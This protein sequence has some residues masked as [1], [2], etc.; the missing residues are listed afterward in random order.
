M[1]NR[2]SSSSS[3]DSDSE[4][5]PS[6][7]SENTQAVERGN[8]GLLV[9]S[10]VEVTNGTISKD[11]FQF[12]EA[13]VV[14]KDIKAFCKLSDFGKVYGWDVV[15][16]IGNS[17]LALGRNDFTYLCARMGRDK[18][19]DGGARGS[20]TPESSGPSNLRVGS[21]AEP[22]L[23]E[24]CHGSKE[25]NQEKSGRGRSYPSWVQQ[26]M[27]DTVLESVEAPFR[28]FGR[29]F[30]LCDVAKK[31]K[32]WKGFP[33]FVAAK[34]EEGGHP[35]FVRKPHH[36]RDVYRKGGFKRLC[37]RLGQDPE[38]KDSDV[39]PEGVKVVN[40]RLYLAGFLSS[41]NPQTR[42]RVK[43]VP[44]V[45][46]IILATDN[47]SCLSGKEQSGE[48]GFTNPAKVQGDGP[49]GSEA[50]TPLY[51]SRQLKDS[52]IQYTLL[53]ANMDV[54]MD[55]IR[56]I[57]NAALA[58]G[59]VQ[60]NDCCDVLDASSPSSSGG[61]KR[62]VCGKLDKVDDDCPE[63][64][65]E[66]MVSKIVAEISDDLNLFGRAYLFYCPTK[67]V[68]YWIGFDAEVQRLAIKDNLVYESHSP[69]WYC[70]GVYSTQRF[71]R[72]LQ[73]S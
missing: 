63:W 44:V 55:T 27:D 48:G 30:L 31:L 62:R 8:S 33:A 35:N 3:E 42:R 50:G 21:V 69:E 56:D 72:V 11:D 24:A 47:M 13:G 18:P 65:V 53:L 6:F 32:Y 64:L 39:V 34:A 66:F 17:A 57:G 16:E 29:G 43:S 38:K 15:G 14:D 71:H 37:K 60:F 46:I 68:V 58:L 51:V 7:V 73:E 12:V 4:T 2:S 26:L 10:D 70:R 23:A 36:F 59:Y 1:V 19:D 54:P 5:C 28:M 61:R 40:E 20:C 67:E 22:E 9:E 45:D 41:P 49:V 25:G 52:V